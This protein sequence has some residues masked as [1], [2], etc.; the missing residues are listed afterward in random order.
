MK[1]EEIFSEEEPPSVRNAPKVEEPPKPDLFAGSTSTNDINSKVQNLKMEDL[2]QLEKTSVRAVAESRDLDDA[3]RDAEQLISLGITPQ[4]EIDV[5]KIVSFEFSANV[6]N[7]IKRYYLTS[8]VSP[9]PISEHKKRKSEPDFRPTAVTILLSLLSVIQR[10][11]NATV[12][13]DSSIIAISLNDMKTVHKLINM[14]VVEGLYG[15]LDPSNRLD[16]EKRTKLKPSTM[17]QD[18]KLAEITYNGISELINEGGDVG[19]LILRAGYYGDVFLLAKTLDKPNFIDTIDTFQLYSILTRLAKNH[20]LVTST[21]SHLP[22][23]SDGVVSLIDFFL[24][25]GNA[26]KS[27]LMEKTIQLL[28]AVPKGI[29]PR[30][31]F[32]SVFTQIRHVLGMASDSDSMK[33]VV[34]MVERLYMT[35]KHHKIVQFEICNFVLKTFKPSREQIDATPLND[36]IVSSAALESGLITLYNLLRVEQPTKDMMDQ[37]TSFLWYYCVA[38]HKQKLEPRVYRFLAEF[39]SKQRLTTVDK[40]VRQI[41]VILAQTGIYKTEF[42]ADGS[43]R[44]ELRKTSESD[45]SPLSILSEIDERVKLFV[46]LLGEAKNPQVANNLFLETLTI[47]LEGGEEDAVKQLVNAKILE[48]L[49]ETHKTAIAQ[50][51]DKVVELVVKLLEERGSGQTARDTVPREADSDDEGDS[52]D[53][54]ESADELVTSSLAILSALSLEDADVSAAIP[55]VKKIMEHNNDL[56]QSCQAFLDSLKPSTAS[57][58]SFKT[59]LK[60]LDDPMIPIRAQGLQKLILAVKSGHVSLEQVTPILLK[61]LGDEDSYIYLNCVKIVQVCVEH[62]PKA[63]EVFSTSYLDKKVSLDVRLKLGEGLAKAIERIAPAGVHGNVLLPK[64]YHVVRPENSYEDAERVSALS[65]ISLVC[66]RN[67]GLQSSENDA[68]DVALGVLSHEKTDI[69]VRRAAARLLVTLTMHM[70]TNEWERVKIQAQF[71]VD[72]DTDELVRGFC[73]EV[74]DYIKIARG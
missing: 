40:T 26:Q 29:Q 34:D 55:A 16:L 71:A 47:W 45:A 6:K 37:I 30:D 8:D 25:T 36:V 19:N 17:F 35:P 14:V 48:V 24:S 33:F 58:F 65:L 44:L 69:D 49:L 32:G 12:H 42:R 73:Q 11:A 9:E 62:F 31:F 4:D 28:T 3:L 22:M 53:E 59:I 20:P 39:F 23:R 15:G 50:D 54:A 66:E 27:V 38:E 67:E 60:L 52:D 68:L 63:L 13:E 56:K 51:P 2:E 72:N 5:A 1:I 57:D 7:D 43:G 64:L 10:R 18:P 61:N 74:L 46:R 70:T 41:S 21:L